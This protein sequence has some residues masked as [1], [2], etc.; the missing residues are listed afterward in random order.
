MT[1]PVTHR[2]HQ[3]SDRLACLRAQVDALANGD[4][5]KT[6]ARPFPIVWPNDAKWRTA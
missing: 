2:S 3:C 4:R 5:L 6:E 1:C